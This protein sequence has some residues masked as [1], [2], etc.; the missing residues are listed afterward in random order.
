M[1]IYLSG[2]MAKISMS[3]LHSNFKLSKSGESIAITD[4][5]GALINGIS[6]SAQNDDISLG[7]SNDGSSDFVFFTSPTPNQ[8][9]NRGLVSANPPEVSLLAGFYTN[10][11]HVTIS[12]NQPG[13]TVGYTSDG[14]EPTTSSGQ[15]TLQITVDVT[16]VIRARTFKSGALD[17][18]IMTNTY[19]INENTTL[20]V[21]SISTDPDNLYGADKGILHSENIYSDLKSAVQTEFFEP[22]GSR[23]FTQSA[24][25]KLSGNSSLSLPSKS[26]A[27]RARGQA[28]AFKYPFFPDKNITKFKSLLLRTSGQDQ[29]TSL[30][31]GGMLQTLLIGQM[32]IDRVAYKPAIVFLN[33]QYHGIRNIREKKNE[34]YLHDNHGVDKDRVDVLQEYAAQVVEGNADHYNALLNFVKNNDIR[35]Q[36]NY[37]YIATQMD[38]SEYMNYYLS[39]IYFG[40][41]D[42]PVKNI[43]FWRAQDGG[44]WRWIFYDMDL[45]FGIFNQSANVNMFDFLLSNYT[46][47]YNQQGRFLFKNLMK[48]NQFKNELAQ[49]LA[50]H[51]NTTFA[52]ARVQ[53]TTD[54]LAAV[55][56][57]EIDAHM[58]YW[59]QNIWPNPSAWELAISSL[60]NY[61]AERPAYVRQNLMTLLSD[62]S[63]GFAG[64]QIQN[65]QPSFGQVFINSVP[66]PKLANFN[67]QWIKDIPL[68]LEAVAAQGKRFVRWEGIANGTHSQTTINLNGNATVR[69]I[70]SD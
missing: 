13:A 38:I 19:L 65:T 20:P 56:R 23:Q 6:F 54:R 59:Y 67:G 29:A 58:T 61:A 7:R 30:L 5:D 35:I 46:E 24:E 36:S 10:A 17:S 63:S 31:R 4:S 18:S 62:R 66:L 15:N 14:S 48:N 11:Q 3:K 28:K 69:A 12:T 1:V 47:N 2:L 40:N 52:T 60:K 8:A 33:G 51:I 57:P 22:Q 32:D 9:N 43:R 16:S 68:K 25:I 27:L 42:W 37:N 53:Q 64:L 26:F 45:A 55:I 49:R 50:G 41:K 34:H 21:F 70:F 44:K 39:E